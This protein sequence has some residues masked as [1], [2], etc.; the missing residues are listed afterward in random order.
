MES[1]LIDYGGKKWKANTNMNKTFE[2]YTKFHKSIAY[3]NVHP[4]LII[5]KYKIKPTDHFLP[6]KLVRLKKK[7]PTWCP[8]LLF[9]VELQS[10][11][12]FLEDS[13]IIHRIL[14][15]L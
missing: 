5:K 3:K 13:F 9:L 11:T 6:S 15:N 12:I 1:A 10:S 8:F 4:L 14:Y 7:L 2:T